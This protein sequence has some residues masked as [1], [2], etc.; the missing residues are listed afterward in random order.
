MDKLY[1]RDEILLSLDLMKNLNSYHLVGQQYLDKTYFNEVMAKAFWEQKVL[2]YPE[3]RV[4][5]F[6]G[7]YKTNVKSTDIYIYLEE[8]D[9]GFKCVG[10]T[11]GPHR[12][13]LNEI[14]KIIC[15][16]AAK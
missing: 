11:V 3:G 1:T 7:K 13:F 15:T 4:H 8:M 14:Y 9:I 16:R 10:I 5:P 2:L 12:T 6:I